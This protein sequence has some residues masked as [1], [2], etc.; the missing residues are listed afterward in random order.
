MKSV[1]VP[2]VKSVMEPLVTAL[3]DG[4]DTPD[5]PALSESGGTADVTALRGGVEAH[6]APAPVIAF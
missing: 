3:R 5:D 2:L 1:V 6:D 4:V